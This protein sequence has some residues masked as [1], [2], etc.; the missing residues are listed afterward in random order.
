MASWSDDD[1]EADTASVMSDVEARGGSSPPRREK[2]ALVC[3][4]ESAKMF[5][6]LLSCLGT[7]RKDQRVRCDVDAR[8]LLVT[9]HSKGKSLQIKTSLSSNLFD[10][11]DFHVGDQDSDDAELTD[12]DAQISFALNLHTLIECVSIF[13]ASALATTSLRL[14]YLAQAARLLLVVEDSGVVCECSMQVLEREGNDVGPMEFESAFEH[15]AVVG[16]CIMQSAPL[17]EAFAELYDLPSAAAVTITMVGQGDDSTTNNDAASGCLKLRATSE[18]GACD[19]AFA[20]RSSA[21][22][23]FFCARS[24]GSCSGTF[25]VAVLQQA[26]KALAQSSE[27]FLRMNDDGF[28]SVQHMIEGPAGER[29]F[30]DALVSPEDTSM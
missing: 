27:T 10:S 22:I 7:G 30:V 1:A 21:F 24:D 5:V 4:M 17:H 29:A 12:D 18:S 9:A 28:L 14:S 23:E 26:L 6:T 8:G 3:T 16:R 2:P 13:G 11:Y 20:P 15:A 25:H 19:I